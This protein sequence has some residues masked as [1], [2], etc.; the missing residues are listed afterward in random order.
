MVVWPLPQVYDAFSE[1]TYS[2]MSTKLL[3]MEIGCPQESGRQE[4]N[5]MLFPSAPHFTSK[6]AFPDASPFPCSNRPLI[7][8][9]FSVEQQTLQNVGVVNAGQRAR[10]WFARQVSGKSAVSQVCSDS[11]T[12]TTTLSIKILVVSQWYSTAF[13]NTIGEVSLRVE[14]STAGASLHPFTSQVCPCSPAPIL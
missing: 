12:C 14:C 6:D 5:C 7:P 13:P 1:N 9:H 4:P 11:D 3:L 8:N 2:R 10:N